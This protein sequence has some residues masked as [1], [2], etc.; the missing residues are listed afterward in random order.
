MAVVRTYSEEQLRHAVAAS[1][2]WRGVLRELGLSATSSSAIRSVRQHAARLALDS[3]HFTGGRRWTDAELAEAVAASRSWSETVERLQLRGGSAVALVQRHAARLGI[4]TA[5]LA[6]PPVEQPS[7]QRLSV[8]LANL[9]RA[10]PQIAAVWFTLCGRDVAWP[11]EPCRYDLLVTG[12]GE[13]RRVQ[14]KTTTTRSENGAWCAHVGANGRYDSRAYTEAEID[15]L[16]VIDGDLSFYLIPL[17]AVRGVHFVHLSAYEGY[18][19]RA[20][21]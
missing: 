18:R 8:G 2:S 13:T 16:F 4:D 11:L 7:S 5:H 12:N 14:V 15:D 20:G 17:E 3:S 10:G 9:S 21:W 19:V 6:Y 1:S